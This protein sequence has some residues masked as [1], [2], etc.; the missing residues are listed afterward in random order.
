MTEQIV[1]KYIRLLI[2]NSNVVSSFAFNSAKR[3]TTLKCVVR[4]LNLHVTQFN[5]TAVKNSKYHTLKH[6]KLRYCKET[7]VA[8]RVLY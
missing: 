4:K 3:Q 7:I 1:D 6:K 8:Y 2:N 5:T